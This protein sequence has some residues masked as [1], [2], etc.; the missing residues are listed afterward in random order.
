MPKCRQ[1]EYLVKEKGEYGDEYCA[2]FGYDTPEKYVAW[3]GEGCRCTKKML[4]KFHEENLK[5][6]EHYIQQSNQYFEEFMRK[7]EPYLYE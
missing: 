3:E 4:K 7:E 1:C 6:E 5:A 2:I